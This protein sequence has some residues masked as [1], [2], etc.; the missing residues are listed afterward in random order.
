MSEAMSPRIVF[1]DIDGC[2]NPADGEPL[3]PGHVGKLSESQRDMLKMISDAIDESGVQHVVLNTGRDF[4]DTN[5]IAEA[6]PTKKV[7]YLLLEHGAYGYDLLEERRIYLTE[8]A[9]SYGM[10]H[11]V[12]RYESILD[13]KKIIK[14]FHLEGYFKLQSRLDVELLP[15][16][17][18][19]A[20]LSLVIPDSMS[21][22]E[23]IELL[24]EEVR[25]AFSESELKHVNYCYSSK[26]VDVIGDVHKSD[27]AHIFLHHLNVSREDTMV[28]GDGMNDMDI[29]K[30]WERLFCPA[31]AHPDIKSLCQTESGIVSKKRFGEAAIDMYQNVC[32]N[33]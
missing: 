16:L 23:L 13:I 4:E 30:I 20:N 14:W 3:P 25:Q 11:L 10:D 32:T 8:L 9:A 1:Q 26:F 22:P 6:L 28:M 17:N 7:R 31:N 5:F 12:F 21:A 27:G 2:L 24:E 18:K 33:D 15:A 19:E 29:F